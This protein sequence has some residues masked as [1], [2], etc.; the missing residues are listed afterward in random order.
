MADQESGKSWRMIGVLICLGFMACGIL[1]P[2]AYTENSNEN[3]KKD[4]ASTG[5]K[6]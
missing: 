6:S 2:G 1:L 3:Q 5:I 4:E